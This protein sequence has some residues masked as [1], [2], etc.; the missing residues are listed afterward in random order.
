MPLAGISVLVRMSS[1]NPCC[2]CL[3]RQAEFQLPSAT[4][5]GSPGSAGGPDLGS[6]RMTTS[7]LIL[8]LERFCVCFF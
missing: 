8:E 4:L 3:S 6:Y 1:Q 2:Q 7:A 5:G